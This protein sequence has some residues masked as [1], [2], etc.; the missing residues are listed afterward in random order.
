MS[1][2]ALF[3]LFYVTLRGSSVTTLKE[4]YENRLR[5]STVTSRYINLEKIKQLFPKKMTKWR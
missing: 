4:K 2:L 1:N 5:R 3:N